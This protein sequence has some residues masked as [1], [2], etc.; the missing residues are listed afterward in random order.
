VPPLELLAF[1]AFAH[2][3]PATMT[4]A[5]ILTANQAAQPKGA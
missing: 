1:D 4:Y 2:A 3:T 5:D